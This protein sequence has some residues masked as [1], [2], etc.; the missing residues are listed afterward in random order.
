MEYFIKLKI[1]FFGIIVMLS[2]TTGYFYYSQKPATMPTA[3]NYPVLPTEKKSLAD[4]PEY[5]K[6]KINAYLKGSPNMSRDYAESIFLEQ[7]AYEDL[8]I[9]ICGR[10]KTLEIKSHCIQLLNVVLKK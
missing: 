4:N 3:S 2:A 6:N 5:L 8:D 10:I 1:I 7:I 9:S